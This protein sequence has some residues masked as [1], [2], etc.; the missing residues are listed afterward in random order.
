MGPGAVDGV[1]AGEL[2]SRGHAID[3][4]TGNTS[5][6]EA[7]NAGGVTLERDGRTRVLPAYIK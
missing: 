4:V 5:I 7:V 6:A 2:L 3:L 1:V